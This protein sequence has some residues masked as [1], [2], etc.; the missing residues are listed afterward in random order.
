M[1]NKTASKNPVPS[2]GDAISVLSKGGADLG[3]DK[4][5]SDIIVANLNMT[6]LPMCVGTP[7]TEIETD[8]VTILF[9]VIDESP[10]M[11]PVE[12]EVIDGF[13]KILIPGLRGGSNKI[14]S[15]IEVGGIAFTEKIKHYMKETEFYA[16]LGAFDR[17]EQAMKKAMAQANSREREEIKISVKMFYKEQAK[18][19]EAELRR[20]QAAR[21]Y[22]KILE[23]RVS[24]QEGA[25]IGGKLLDLYKKLGKL[26]EYQALEKSI[27]KP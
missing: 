1:T 12:Q 26:H 24:E 11:T 19:C 18:I 25:E 3:L 4:D 13:N 22:E 20:N 16:R 5:S 10:S 17:V 7:I 14:T 9:F 23:M 15:T 6:T 2:K 27:Q 8:D 21:F